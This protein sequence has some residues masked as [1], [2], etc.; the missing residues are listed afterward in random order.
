MRHTFASK[1]AFLFR[2]VSDLIEDVEAK[3]DLFKSAVIASAVANCGCKC[4][5]GQTVSQRE[6]A[7]LNQKINKA[8]VQ[9]KLRLEL[10]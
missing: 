4:V 8:T 9:R 10:G 1:V 2:E 5:G 6:T 3:W 7:W